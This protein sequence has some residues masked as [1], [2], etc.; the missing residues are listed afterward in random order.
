MA[1]NIM[2]I[3]SIIVLLVGKNDKPFGFLSSR[4]LGTTP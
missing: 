3:A 4:F 2:I 1:D